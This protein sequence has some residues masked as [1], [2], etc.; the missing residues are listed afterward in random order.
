MGF[1]GV[2]TT[3]HS[4]CNIL[5][6][7]NETRIGPLTKT[8]DSKAP[9]RQYCWCNFLILVKTFAEN[10]ISWCLWSFI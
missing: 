8:A 1:L 2:V 10:H 9:K 5:T 6:F 7:L 4:T 3:S